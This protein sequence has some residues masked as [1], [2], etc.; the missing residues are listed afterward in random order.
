MRTTQFALG[1]LYH[2]YNRGVDKRSLFADV[3]D[4]HR[5]LIAFRLSNQ[6][7]IV[8]S[9]ANI[10]R[11]TDVQL[12]HHEVASPPLVR[13]HTYCINQNHFHFIL[14]P[15]VDEGVQKFMHR[16]ATAYTNYF[17]TRHDRTGSLFQGTYKAKHIATNEYFMHLGCYI[18]YNNLVHKG[19][20]S[21]WLEKLAF[22]ALGEYGGREENNHIAYTKLLCAQ[23]K[24]APHFLKQAVKVARHVEALRRESNEYRKLC[25][26]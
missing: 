12:V 16:L 24:S 2:I 14:E 1:S 18:T 23:Y 4:F 17:N 3:A 11:D 5:F 21:A 22:S 6:V 10:V 19:L 9:F 20:N 13:V 26:E 25:L 15:L 7:D 8:G